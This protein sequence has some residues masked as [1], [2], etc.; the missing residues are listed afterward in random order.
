MNFSCCYSSFILKVLL[1]SF[2]LLFILPILVAGDVLT[3]F[4]GTDYLSKRGL[5][6]YRIKSLAYACTRAIYENRYT[7]M[8][9][10]ISLYHTSHHEYF[11]SRS[12]PDSYPTI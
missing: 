4:G 1:R 10:F 8:E 5:V 9:P 3:L 7:S 12:F 6:E 11:L 2:I